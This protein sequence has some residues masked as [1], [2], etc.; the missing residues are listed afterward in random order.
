MPVSS[1]DLSGWRARMR[2]ILRDERE[3]KALDILA[4]AAANEPPGSPGPS[5]VEWALMEMEAIQAEIE[6]GR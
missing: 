4:R 1:D 3:A 2:R 5:Q 6:N